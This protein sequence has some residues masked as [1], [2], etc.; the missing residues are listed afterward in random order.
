MRVADHDGSS[1]Y[2]QSQGEGRI[3]HQKVLEETA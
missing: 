1:V 3:A 2:F